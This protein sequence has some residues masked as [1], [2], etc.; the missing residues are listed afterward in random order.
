MTH[1]KLF[2]SLISINSLLLAGLLGVV[3]I[4]N[5]MLTAKSQDL[6]KLKAEVQVL[7]EFQSSIS[8]NKADIRK[9]AQLNEIA[10]TIVPQDKDQTQTVREI[11]KMSQESGIRSLSS[12]TFPA[13]DLGGAGAAQRKPISQALQVK[14]IEGVYLL[15]ITVTVETSGPA[16]YNQF[17]T[18]LQKL[19]N[20]RRTSQISDITIR[21]DQKNPELIAFTLKINEYIKP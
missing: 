15:P 5:T 4:G 10:K 1:K 17:M 19:E 14:G 9:Y 2:F 3:Y 8:K 7:D 18:F 16:T 12:I 6:N 13:S 20:N 11:V 21:P